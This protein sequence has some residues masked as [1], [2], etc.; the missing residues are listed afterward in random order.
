MSVRRLLP[1]LVVA[2][3]LVL[4]A[5][6]AAIANIPQRDA[7]VLLSITAGAAVVCALI[8]NVAL[9]RSRPRSLRTQA[10]VI[11]ATST[12]AVIAGVTA[13]AKAMFISAHDRDVLFVVVALAASASLAAALQLASSFHTDAELVD[14]MTDRLGEPDARQ[15]MPRGLRIREMEQLANKLA[16]ANARLEEARVR[17]RA[18]EASRRELVAWISHDLRSP[19]ASV[20]ALA[21]SLEDHI[22]V[23][24]AD[25]ERY[26]RSI[27][28]ESERL[29]TLVDDLFEL[30]RLHAGS[31]RD[32]DHTIAIQELVFDAVAGIAVAAE[33]KGVRVE[34][35]ID[36]VGPVAVPAA[37][38]LRIV[39]NLLD[40]AVRH[41][42]PGGVVRLEGRNEEAAVVLSV[43]DECGGIPEGD[44]PRVFDVAFRGD[45]ARQRDGSS[46]G[47]GLTIAKGLVEAHAGSIAVRNLDRGCQFRVRIPD[48]RIPA[49]R[50]P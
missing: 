42:P 12:A 17:E 13:A 39:R 47:L 50:R 18:I 5:V 28:L 14:R 9:H 35:D 29:T 15:L 1:A 31:A 3:G 32:L 36:P 48:E 8:G 46:G 7:L 23:D 24:P 16:D 49:Q 37:D 44:L 2:A 4:G 19:L 43:L 40:N 33:V 20:R 34:V 21:E 30:S 38:V 41:T 45:T 11:G 27:R 6:I 10:I 25:I 22:V 26:H